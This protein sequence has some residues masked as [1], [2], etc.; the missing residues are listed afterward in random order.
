MGAHVQDFQIEKG[1][2]ETREE[3]RELVKDFK[4]EIILSSGMILRKG[5][6]PSCHCGISF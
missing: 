2:Q 5:G 3:K 6:N 1:N 4:F